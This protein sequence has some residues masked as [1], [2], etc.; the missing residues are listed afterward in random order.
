[1]LALARH[2]LL[3]LACASAVIAIP[4]R[5]FS[6]CFREIDFTLCTNA[7]PASTYPDGALT[8]DLAIRQDAVENCDGNYTS[9]NGLAF[10][11]YCGQ[12]N[13]QNGEARATLFVARERLTY[14]W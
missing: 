2:S 7:P 5:M 13:P 10:T 11:I 8:R 3:A 6:D 1:M 4:A 12:N 9:K 14:Q